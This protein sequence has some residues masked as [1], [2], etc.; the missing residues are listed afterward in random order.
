MEKLMDESAYHKEPYD[1]AE[2]AR[3]SRE[4]WEYCVNELRKLMTPEL[5]C[6]TAVFMRCQLNLSKD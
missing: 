2:K 1:P 3:H 5:M 4:N 6:D